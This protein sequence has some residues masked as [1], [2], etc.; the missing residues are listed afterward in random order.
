MK[1]SEILKERRGE[2]TPELKALVLAAVREYTDPAAG[3]SAYL[4][5]RD[6]HEVA[7]VMA[8]LLLAECD[9]PFGEETP[10]LGMIYAGSNSER[11]AYNIVDG[12]CRYY[13]RNLGKADEIRRQIREYYRRQKA[14][15]GDS[16]WHLVEK[17][18]GEIGI[19]RETISVPREKIRAISV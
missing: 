3:V 10:L 5:M 4:L 17:R 7:D 6:N 15:S 8:E 2:L 19:E 11:I 9:L 16:L 13:W 1:I 12:L 18:L 14:V